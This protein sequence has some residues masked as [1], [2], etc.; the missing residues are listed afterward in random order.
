VELDASH[1]G[2]LCSGGVA[3]HVNKVHSV[4]TI[5]RGGANWTVKGVKYGKAERDQ[6]N[7]AIAR[8]TAE[9]QLEF[10]ISD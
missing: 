9:C 5:G 10:E 8:C 1:V 2:V 7:I 6:C 3:M 4:L